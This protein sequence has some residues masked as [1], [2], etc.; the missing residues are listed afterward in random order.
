MLVEII[1]PE[2][3][4]F[5]GEANAVSLPGSDGNFQI[6]N[7]HAAII[8][9]LKKGEIKLS[10]S[11]LPEISGAIKKVSNTEIAIE[12]NGGMAEFMKN[13]LVVLAN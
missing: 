6:L 10:L 5:S 2:K 3:Q 9:S 1:T 12:I 4:L 13:K 7:N 11:V 8:S